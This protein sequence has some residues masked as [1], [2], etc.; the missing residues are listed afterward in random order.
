MRIVVLGG[1]FGEVAAVGHLEPTD[2]PR[3]WIFTARREPHGLERGKTD[4][5]TPVLEEELSNIELALVKTVAAPNVTH[6]KFV[7][8]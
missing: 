8:A 3:R 2:R 1:G 7:R 4:E 5:S 6:L